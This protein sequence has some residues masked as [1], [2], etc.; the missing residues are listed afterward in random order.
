MTAL[1]ALMIAV[2]APHAVTA[3]PITLG[4][5]LRLHSAALGEMRTVNVVLPLGYAKSQA[6]RYPVLYVIDGG[7]DQDLVHV[8]GTAMLGAMWG[9]S[10]NAIVVGIETIDRRRELTGPTHDP[11]LLKQYPTAGNSA[12]FRA[13]IRGEVKPL[14]AKRYRTNGQDAVIGESL[15]GL[16]I[17]E[18]WLAEPSLFGAYGAISPSLWWDQEAL[19]K[20]AAAQIGKRQAGHALY[21]ATANEGGDMQVPVDR[22]V[23]ALTTAAS[24]WCY[25]PQAEL[26]HATIYHSVSPSALAYLLPPAEKPDPQFGFQVTCAAKR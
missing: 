11:K 13:F 20:A 26:T 16:F 12:A 22:L 15:A 7:V 21:L 18:T 17:T 4:T 23:G 19:S 3:E 2:A 6:K 8:A 1:T 5:S 24:G 14:V 25:A 9:R 10:Q